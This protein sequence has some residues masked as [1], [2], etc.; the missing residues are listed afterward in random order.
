MIFNIMV[1]LVV[2]KVLDI[3]CGPQED[4]HVL[5]WVMGERNVVF[6]AKN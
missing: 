1:D 6:C 2:Q 3:V 5:G 4:E